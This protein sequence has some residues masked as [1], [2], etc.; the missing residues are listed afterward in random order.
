MGTPFKLSG[1]N[2]PGKSPLRQEEKKQKTEKE[3]A[4]AE[5]ESY[6]PKLKIELAKLE[7]GDISADL[8][9]ISMARTRIQELGKHWKSPAD[10]SGK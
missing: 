9:F 2:Y 8:E 6:T 5:I 10:T 4:S 1:Y 3:K 7:A